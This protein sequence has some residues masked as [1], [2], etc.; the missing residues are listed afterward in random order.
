MRNVNFKCL[1]CEKE[2]LSKKACKSRLP[3][4]CSKACFSLSLRKDRKCPI[5]ECFVYWHNKIYCSKKCES[6][7]KKGKPLSDNHKKKLSDAKI[8]RK[9]PHLHT[10]EVFKKI[11]SSLKGKAQPWMRGSNHP[12]YKDGG[13][14]TSERLKAMGR[15]EYKVWRRSVFKR[16]DFTCVLCNA[17]GKLIHADHIK[18]WALFPEL[19]YEINNGRTLCVK[20]HRQTST[21][22]GVR[23]K[24]ILMDQK[25]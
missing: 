15:V 5:C 11:S 14:G 1:K 21:W 9:I 24:K 10:L 2:F 13:V 7:F 22:G 12:N 23:R 17:R 25:L 3:K 8:G 20:C 4:Y 18:P 19:R 6:E 16:D